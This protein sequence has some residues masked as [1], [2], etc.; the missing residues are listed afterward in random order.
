L[1]FL[2]RLN[3]TVLTTEKQDGAGQSALEKRGHP[4]QAI[5]PKSDSPGNALLP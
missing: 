5:L 3:E 1:R 4:E 2:H